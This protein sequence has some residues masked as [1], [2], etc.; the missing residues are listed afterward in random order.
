MPERFNLNRIPGFMEE[1]AEWVIKNLQKRSIK[2]QKAAENQIK[3]G[4]VIHIM[5]KT[6]TIRVLATRQHKPFVK[7]ARALKYDGDTAYYDNEEIII[8]MPRESSTQGG[9]L[10]AASSSEIKKALEKHLR[11]KAKKLFQIRTA[12]IAETMGL[13]YNRVT[14]K[15]QKTRWGSC[16]R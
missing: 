8:F 9:D 13:S 15:A 4:S 2:K 11:S 3:D 7:E 5:G 10:H 6:K 12:Q 16:S 14:V 1:H